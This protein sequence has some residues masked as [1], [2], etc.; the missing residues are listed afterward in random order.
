MQILSVWKSLKFV[1]LERVNPLPHY[2]DIM[3]DALWEM[4][5][6]PIPKNLIF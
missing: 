3:T 4:V 6:M 5:K 2:P 1:V